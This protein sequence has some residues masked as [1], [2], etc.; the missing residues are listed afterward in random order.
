MLAASPSKYTDYNLSKALG[1]YLAP[2]KEYLEKYPPGPHP[3]VDPASINE[4]NDSAELGGKQ[5]FG[6]LGD[7]RVPGPQAFVN[8]GRKSAPNSIT[9]PHWHYAD[10]FQV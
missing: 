2:S 3:E 4:P 7:R 1:G 8:G 5:I 9:P 10:Q 6:V